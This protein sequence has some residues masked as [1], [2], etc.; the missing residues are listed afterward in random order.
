MNGYPAPVI[1]RTVSVY[2]FGAIGDGFHDDSEAIQRFFDFVVSHPCRKAA[3]FGVFA[4]SRTIVVEGSHTSLDHRG[5]EFL[6]RGPETLLFES[7][8]KFLAIQDPDGIAPETVLTFR[9]INNV[10]FKGLVSVS[11]FVEGKARHPRSYQPGVFG[12]TDGGGVSHQNRMTDFGIRFENCGR[13]RFDSLRASDCRVYGLYARAHV[14]PGREANNNVLLDLGSVSA[15]LCGASAYATDP[16]ETYWHTA[17][18]SDPRLVPESRPKKSRVTVTSMPPE[19]AHDQVICEIGG[20]YYK[21]SGFD[22]EANTLD[23]KPILDNTRISGTAKYFYGGA[24][25]VSGNNCALIN[26]DQ[27][28]AYACGIALSDEAQY[29]P[30]VKRVV[31]QLCGIGVLSSGIGTTINGLYVEDDGSLAVLIPRPLHNNGPNIISTY[32]FGADRMHSIA[33]NR[34]PTNNRVAARADLTGTNIMAGGRLRQGHKPWSFHSNESSSALAFGNWGGSRVLGE[35]FTF[36]RDNWRVALPPGGGR[37]SADSLRFQE[38]L[39]DHRISGHDSVRFTFMGN[40]PNHGPQA[41]RRGFVF[42][43]NNTG[44]KVNGAESATI[45]PPAGFRFAGPV[46]VVAH[47]R[48][49]AAT[50]DDRYNILVSQVAG[51]LEPIA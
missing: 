4:V 48:F 43:C 25:R 13:A 9:N 21:A 42:V 24:V 3:I 32:G 19:N 14:R 5:I 30:I 1:D 38:F 37:P 41:D 27:I 29:G 50:D 40:G 46:E 35:H 33:D 22:Y 49:D 39:D 2:E 36:Y 6:F 11:G 34:N 44:W 28:D 18:W 17:D 12:V 45:K 26:I 7:N 20:E 23:L 31:S 10:V 51:P 16:N 47:Y 15:S 8:A